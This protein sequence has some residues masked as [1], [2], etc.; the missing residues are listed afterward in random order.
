MIKPAPL[1]ACL[2]LALLPFLA[3]QETEAPKPDD[4][5]REVEQVLTDFH[6]AAA[7]AD[8]RRFFGLLADDAIYMGT[9]PAER[10][11]RG[12]LRELLGPSFEAGQGWRTS[13]R[14]THVF[15]AD[16]GRF[17]WFDEALESERWGPMRGSGVLRKEDDGWRIVQYNTAFTIP[18][19][20][21][22]DLTKQ[23]RELDG[24]R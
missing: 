22:P 2:A 8:A 20:L 19:Q 23:I 17:A 16:D 7:R 18:N 5:T 13:A 24:G 15:V 1:T 12:R 6:R 9:D 3:P 4:A 14:E 21:V 11:T 10:W